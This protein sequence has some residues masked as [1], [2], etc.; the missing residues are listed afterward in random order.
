MATAV[1]RVSNL[2][3]KKFVQKYQKTGTPVIFEDATKIWN[4]KEDVF[5]P[6]FFKEKFGDRITK[7]KDKVYTITDILDL[8]AASTKEI[9]AP[10]PVKFNVLTKLPELLS[11]MQPLNMNYLKPNWLKAKVF[12]GRLM[13]EMDLH[14]GGI[15]NSY[16]V[17]KDAYHVHAWLIQ[18]YGEKEVI[19]FPRGQEDRLYAG[20]KG[21]L[22]SRSPVNISNPDY[23]KYPKFKD[24]V[25]IKETLKAGQVMYI[26]SGMWHTTMAYGQNISTIIDQMNSSNFNNWLKDVYS[27]KAHYSKPRAVL[28]FVAATAIGAACWIGD[29]TGVK[30]E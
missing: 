4:N 1:D 15:G 28:D 10:Y 19:V 12:K 23:D 22:A 16:E 20:K 17:H 6:K 21:L 5:T 24:I 3:Y 13:N 26:P 2:P 27:Y 7:F 29:K 14:I 30:F 9:P 18:L 11:Y 8:T 25:Q